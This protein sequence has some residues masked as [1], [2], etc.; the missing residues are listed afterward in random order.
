MDTWKKYMCIRPALHDVPIVFMKKKTGLERTEN[1]KEN[2]EIQAE[3][4][5][6]PL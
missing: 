6:N 2:A 1:R 5:V 4:L 3:H